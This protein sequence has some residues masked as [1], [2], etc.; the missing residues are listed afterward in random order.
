[1]FVIYNVTDKITNDPHHLA[2]HLV[3][4]T[5]DKHENDEVFWGT[6]TRS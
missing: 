2:Y 3:S 4:K 6:Q 1:M 5:F